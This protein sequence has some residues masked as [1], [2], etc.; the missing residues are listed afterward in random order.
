MI[1]RLPARV[2]KGLVL[3]AC[4]GVL[5]LCWQE[6]FDHAV[7]VRRGED[8]VLGVRFTGMVETPIGRASHLWR[9]ESVD[10]DSPASKV[11]APGMVVRFANPLDPWRRY[12]EQNELSVFLPGG[13]P[14][15][16][17]PIGLM[18]RK[19][20]EA[21]TV[22]TRAR[23]AL[24][25]M[26]VAFCLLLAFAGQTQPGYRVLALCFLAL[27][28]NLFITFNYMR[29]DLL[30]RVGKLAN[31]A[32]YPLSWYLC[33]AFF[34]RYR[35]YPRTPFRVGLLRMFAGYRW[36]AWGCA[37]YALWY[38]SGRKAPGL[39]ALTLT[40]VGGGLFL[41]LATLAD[42]LGQSSGELRQRHRWLLLSVALGTVPSMLAM[43]PSLSWTG[44]WGLRWMALACYLGLA[45][46]Y[47]G[48]IWAVLRHRVFNFSFALGR[49]LLGSVVSALLVC[50][51]GL[52][53][54]LVTHPLKALLQLEHRN[55]FVEGMVALAVYAGF[56]QIHSRSEHQLERTLFK[57]WHDKEHALREAVR[58]AAHI[59]EQ[60]SLLTFLVAALDTFTDEAGAAVYLA[61]AD[62]GFRRAAFTLADCPARLEL[63]PAHRDRFHKRG[64][65]ERPPCLP[66]LGRDQ[67]VFPMNHRGRLNGLVVAGARADGETYRPDEC[68]VMAY[69]AQQVGIDLDTLRIEELERRMAAL[70]AKFGA[71]EAALRLLAG[72]RHGARAEAHP[73]LSE[74]VPTAAGG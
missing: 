59:T 73:A 43:I 38:G 62:G 14:A 10:P 16:P 48:F 20:P 25:L 15:H 4:L 54:S 53:E 23:L 50:S 64:A 72:R 34:L 70:R 2:W 56:H 55:M 12:V 26:A 29:D 8:R 22:D 45:L 52:A 17:T 42:G 60:Q 7:A 41:T 30:L 39:D 46:M 9:V 37:G 19:I 66:G 1:A 65:P 58:R 44:P 40:V 21:D 5:A 47:I 18:T 27:S 51:V 35:T 74:G 63:D 33:A 69:A 68:K 57:R 32:A 28:L 6:A 61:T 31:L 71:Q 24:S 67:M 13:D 11:L 36:L 49:V 3:L